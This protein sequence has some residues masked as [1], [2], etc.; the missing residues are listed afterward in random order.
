MNTKSISRAITFGLLRALSIIVGI[1]FLLW[2][3]YEIQSVLVY[4]AIAAVISLI[5][6]PVTI[7]FRE[8]FRFPNTLAVISTLGIV[9]SIFAG[10]IALFIPILIEQSHHIG[11]ID[12][13]PLQEDMWVLSQQIGEYLNIRKFDLMEVIRNSSYVR[14]INL[15]IIPEF[16]NSIFG[17]FGAAMIG[18]FSVLFIAFFLLKDSYLLQNSMLAF[19][20]HKDEGRFVRAFTKIKDLLS[21]YF[22]GLTLQVLIIFVLYSVL[23]LIFE[24]NNAIAIAFF[25]AILNLV[26]YLGPLIAGGLMLTLST[27]SHLGQDFGSVILPKLIYI[28]IGYMIVQVIDNFINQ[29]FIFGTSVKSHPL[30]IFLAII[31]A[32]LLFGVVGMIVAVP[33]YTAIKVISK[34]FLSEYKIVKQ[35][36]KEL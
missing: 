13:E 22:L 26:P 25:C 35:L 33:V 30:E 21:R 10:I 27:T 3:L 11:E 5:G 34:E 16:L 24:I 31:I 12:L 4:I 15:Q 9:L 29:P 20:S 8:K 6:R 1:L 7:F 18:L 17:M 32:G 2:F 36:T 23:L 14:D 19:V 28:G